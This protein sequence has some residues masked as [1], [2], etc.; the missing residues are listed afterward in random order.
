MLTFLSIV[1]VIIVTYKFYFKP[2]HS[3]KLT[4]EELKTAKKLFEL[5]L[6]YKEMIKDMA[7]KRNNYDH[8]LTQ[9]TFERYKTMPLHIKESI[10]LEFG[11]IPLEKSND[12]GTS[13]F[14]HALNRSKKANIDEITGS[15][16]WEEAERIKNDLTTQLYNLS[17]DPEIILDPYLD[18]DIINSIVK[19]KILN[20]ATKLSQL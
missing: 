14:M 17:T 3:D 13:I 16:N 5:Q 20:T 1:A 10:D 11:S 8:S 6:V 18:T 2:N 4:Q 12:I 9:K 7:L 15:V 19:E